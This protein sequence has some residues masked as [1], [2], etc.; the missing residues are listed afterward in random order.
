[1]SSERRIA[2][3]M[4]TI[5]LQYAKYSKSEQCF[6]LSYEDIPAHEIDSLVATL[7]E[8]DFSASEACG[9][10]NDEFELSMRPALVSALRD[11]AME[12][13][14]HEFSKRWIAGIRKYFEKRLRHELEHIL[15]ELNNDQE[16][17][18]E[19]YREEVQCESTQEARL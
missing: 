5:V 13:V 9:P 4:N 16:R 14:N 6:N 17:S 19:H 8:D 7:M 18:D 1:M 2:C 10:D 11:H 12:L 3:G 15:N